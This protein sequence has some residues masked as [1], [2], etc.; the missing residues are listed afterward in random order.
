[1][2]F[3]LNGTG[4]RYYGEREHDIG[5]QYTTTLWVV[6]FAIPLVPLSSWRVYPLSEEQSIDQSYFHNRE[7]SNTEQHF[8][9]VRVPLNWRQVRNVYSVTLTGLSVV[10]WLLYRAY[11][12]RS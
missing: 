10:G 5:R 11:G 1:M 8:Q 3:T 12:M 2:P 7:V 4:T 9:A 6:V